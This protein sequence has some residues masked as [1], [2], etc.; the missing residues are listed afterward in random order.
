MDILGEWGYLKLYLPRKLILRLDF[1]L[2]KLRPIFL[3]L[4]K[5]KL[6]SSRVEFL[7]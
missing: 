5:N 6:I 1:F 3:N 2:V 7:M 4:I